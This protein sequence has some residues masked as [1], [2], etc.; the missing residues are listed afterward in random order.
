MKAFFLLLISF[1]VINAHSQT[2]IT[3]GKIVYTIAM[4]D[5]ATK[6]DIDPSKNQ[7]MTVYFK[8]DMERVEGVVIDKG[9]NEVIIIG[10]KTYSFITLIDSMGKKVAVVSAVEDVNSEHGIQRK[11]NFVDLNVTKIILGHTCKGVMFDNQYWLGTIFLF[12]TSDYYIHLLNPIYYTYD[13]VNG[14]VMSIEQY[15]F[16]LAIR[17]T[18]TSISDQKVDDSMFEIPSDYQIK[19]LKDK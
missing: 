12:Y 8:G 9:V 6:K 11:K 5:S 18:V 14:F 15:M 7:T 3:E 13:K 1:V 16:G 17:C 19:N 2:T 10:N 4:F